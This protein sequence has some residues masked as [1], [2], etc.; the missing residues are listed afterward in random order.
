MGEI[1]IFPNKNGTFMIYQSFKRGNH[2]YHIIN[3][4]PY[5]VKKIGKFRMWLRQIFG[6]D[7]PKDGIIYELKE[8]K[9]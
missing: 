2:K 5:E 9:R 1:K 4:G 3:N 7:N 6:L 8:E